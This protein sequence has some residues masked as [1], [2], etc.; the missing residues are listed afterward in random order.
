MPGES[1]RSCFSE[2]VLALLEQVSFWGRHGETGSRPGQPRAGASILDTAG[3]SEKVLKREPQARQAGA[4]PPESPEQPRCGVSQTLCVVLKP[5]PFLPP[6]F[7]RCW[8]NARTSGPATSWSIAVFLDLTF[9]QEAVN[10][11]WSPLN[12][13]LVSNLR[14][15]QH[16]QGVG[17]LTTMLLQLTF[18]QLRNSCS[19]E[20][21][22]P[23]PPAFLVCVYLCACCVR[24]CTDLC[25]FLQIPEF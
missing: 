8:T 16:A 22:G 11:S 23:V 1:N 9:V 10:T 18:V 19:W 20:R 12:A 5:I 6:H 3:T 13:N 25:E 17:S 21:R 24:T 15:A 7:R 2:G 4:L 14:G